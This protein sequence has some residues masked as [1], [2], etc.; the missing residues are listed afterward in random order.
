VTSRAA[1]DSKG[2]SDLLNL[3]G[4]GPQLLQQS[5]EETH[6][7]ERSGYYI[8][9]LY[10]QRGLYWYRADGRHGSRSFPLFEKVVETN[11]ER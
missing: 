5:W 9:M 1:Y 6:P 8:T 4:T 10:Q 7:G 11:L 3:D 2:I